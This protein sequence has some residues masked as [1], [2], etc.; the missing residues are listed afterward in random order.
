M[1]SD[2]RALLNQMN[3]EA[4]EEACR[5]LDLQRSGR[6]IDELRDAIARK[7]DYS[8]KPVKAGEVFSL[9]TLNIV[10][11]DVRGRPRRSISDAVDEIFDWLNNGEEY[12]RNELVQDAQLR[13][14]DGLAPILRSPAQ[15]VLHLREYIRELPPVDREMFFRLARNQP[16]PG[17]P[18]IDPLRH[19]FALLRNLAAD[20]VLW[21]LDQVDGRMTRESAFERTISLVHKLAPNFRIYIGRTFVRQG[22]EHRGLMSRW[23]SHANSK[24]MTHARVL[25]LS[26]HDMVDRDELLAIRLVRLWSD[27]NMLCCNNDVVDKTPSKAEDTWHA[28]Y[29]CIKPRH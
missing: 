29:I 7:L 3:R 23:T 2:L 16:G 11:Q 10:A 9:D 1:A 21:S 8:L 28:L 17:S 27:F 22:D 19:G 4:L 14:K 24:N 6:N 25:G 5:S 13:K 18:I 12:A 20:K 15:R 26:H